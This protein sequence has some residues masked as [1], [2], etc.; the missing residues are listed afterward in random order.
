MTE[1]QSLYHPLSQW[2]RCCNGQKHFVKALCQQS[3]N[4]STGTI[5]HLKTVEVQ[6]Q[7]FI[8]L[9]IYL[10]ILLGGGEGGDGVQMQLYHFILTTVK[11]I[12]KTK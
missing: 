5:W 8:Y 4:H 12:G 3:G 1:F 7:D 10:F 2:K 11:E 6:I 9:S